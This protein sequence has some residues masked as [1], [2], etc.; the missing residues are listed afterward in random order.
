MP[1]DLTENERAAN[2][3]YDPE[4]D[5][6]MYPVRPG[7]RFVRTM[8]PDGIAQYRIESWG[9]Y[10]PCPQSHFTVSRLSKTRISGS[11]ARIPSTKSST[12]VLSPRFS[13]DAR[14]VL[15]AGVLVWRF[16]VTMRLARSVAIRSAYR[17]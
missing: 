10:R 6:V 11:Q 5:R 2:F 12:G 3:V 8:R 4:T 9:L 7:M 15:L 14:E 1:N 17:D 16:S 13:G